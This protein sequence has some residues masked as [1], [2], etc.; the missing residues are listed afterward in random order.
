MPSK[1]KSIMLTNLRV[2]YLL[3]KRLLDLMSMG[4]QTAI[5]CMLAIDSVIAQFSN[6]LKMI[7]CGFN[8]CITA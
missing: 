7:D 2:S 6:I 5:S 1:A 3:P 4:L 8:F